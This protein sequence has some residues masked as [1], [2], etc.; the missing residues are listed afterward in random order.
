MTDALPADEP[1]PLT[2]DE[3]KAR[4]DAV[5]MSQPA[6]RTEVFYITLQVASTIGMMM[7]LLEQA[8]ANTPANAEKIAAAKRLSMLLIKQSEALAVKRDAE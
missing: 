5:R 6:T 1:K 8:V 3:F 4:Y 7:Q 2:A